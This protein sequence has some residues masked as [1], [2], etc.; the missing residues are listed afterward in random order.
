MGV[1]EIFK[2]ELVCHI[3][4]LLVFFLILKSVIIFPV[5]SFCTISYIRVFH[6]NILMG[7]NI[8]R[9]IISNF[10]LPKFEL[11]MRLSKWDFLQVYQT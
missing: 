7:N 3:A 10:K 2:K 1:L 5:C 8:V 6:L 9:L 4:N 11:F